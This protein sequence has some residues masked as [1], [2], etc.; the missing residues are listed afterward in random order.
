ML[1]TDPDSMNPDPQHCF[2]Y[3][4]TCWDW[5]RQDLWSIRFK[6]L[7]KNCKQLAKGKLQSTIHDNF[8]KQFIITKKNFGF[9]ISK[10]GSTNAKKFPTRSTG[11]E[12]K[13]PNVCVGRIAI[14]WEG[15]PPGGSLSLPE[16][17]FLLCVCECVVSRKWYNTFIHKHQLQ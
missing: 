13:N 3:L 5:N 4:W 15:D 6:M 12:C 1:D 17:N 7:S 10:V 2:V 8:F 16:M 9:L 11:Q 14:W